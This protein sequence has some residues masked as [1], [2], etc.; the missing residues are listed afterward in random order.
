[1][2]QE[3]E[4]SKEI[5]FSHYFIFYIYSYSDYSIFYFT[6]ITFRL[7]SYKLSIL[8]IKQRLIIQV[9]VNRTRGSAVRKLASS[10]NSCNETRPPIAGDY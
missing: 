3:V 10:H 2:L 1:M 6:N 8:Q 4:T 9:S 7:Y 5:D